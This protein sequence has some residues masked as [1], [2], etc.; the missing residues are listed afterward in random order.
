MA[1]KKHVEA[2]HG[3]AWKV[4]YG[5]FITSLMALFMVLWILTQNVEVKESIANYFLDP[6]S[7]KV[8]RSPGIVPRLRWSCCP[9]MR[10]CPSVRRS[11]RRRTTLT[12]GARLVA[13]GSLR[14]PAS[15]S[16]RPMPANRQKPASAGFFL[17]R[18]GPL[19]AE[20]GHST[21]FQARNLT[22]LL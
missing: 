2:H 21:H 9:R 14:L 15:D 20:S 16:P 11:S 1:K 4:A 12:T 6:F 3:G 5:D 22:C 18:K 19:L 10:W 7:S 17:R 8:E 13:A